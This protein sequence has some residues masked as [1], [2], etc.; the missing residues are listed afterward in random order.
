MLIGILRS[1]FSVGGG[2]GTEERKKTQELL[3][4]YEKRENL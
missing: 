3:K 4:R 2:M 1:D